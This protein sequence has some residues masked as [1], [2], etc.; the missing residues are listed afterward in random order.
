[1]LSPT[2][3]PVNAAF[4]PPA[5]FMPTPSRASLNTESLSNK[6]GGVYNRSLPEL[7]LDFKYIISSRRL[8]IQEKQLGSVSNLN[9]NIF[10]SD[11]IFVCGNEKV[12]K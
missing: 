12:F 9:Q 5:P 8:Q 10:E 7:P 1:M 4:I 3:P 11:G 6:A 2:L